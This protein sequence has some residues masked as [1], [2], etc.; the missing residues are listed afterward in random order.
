MTSALTRFVGVRADAAEEM[1]AMTVAQ[2][3]SLLTDDLLSRFGE[4]A[5]VHEI[6]GKAALG[7]AGP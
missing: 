7:L 1:R 6:V 2:E 3:S 5:A 4:C